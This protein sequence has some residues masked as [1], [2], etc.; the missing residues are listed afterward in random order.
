MTQ[1][2]LRGVQMMLEKI[3]L[4]KYLKIGKGTKNVRNPHILRIL[5]IVHFFDTLKKIGT[6]YDFDSV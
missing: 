5:F 1:L 4:Q 2:H 6:S 3:I